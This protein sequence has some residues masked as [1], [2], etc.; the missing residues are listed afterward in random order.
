MENNIKKSARVFFALWPNAEERAALAAWQLPLKQL[1][2]GRPA[3]VQ[4]LHNTLV[5]LGD[6]EYARLEAL[7]LAAQEAGSSGFQLVFDCARYWGHNHI[8][9]AAPAS[10]P[11]HLNLLVQSLQQRLLQHQFNFDRRGYKPHV[12]LLRDAHWTDSP[13]PEMQA[14][15][16]KS[17]EFALV[18]SVNEGAGVR[19]EVLARFPAAA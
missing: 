11:E 8:V 5:F 4:N 1:C 3:P 17:S 19:Y 13:L 2:G 14:V 18:Q 9:F 6:V 16:W 12:T 7:Q 10:V 15:R